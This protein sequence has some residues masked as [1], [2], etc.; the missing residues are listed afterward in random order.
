M[1]D[2]V[3][4]YERHFSSPVFA[5][6]WATWGFSLVAVLVG[7]RLTADP[8]V[9]G[10]GL[11]MGQVALV[12][13]LSLIVAAIILSVVATMA[14]E[15]GLNTGMLLRPAFGIA[16]SWLFSAIVAV[17]YLIWTALE[18]N[19]AATLAIAS[20]DVL[21]VTLAEGVPI[22]LGAV[23]IGALS[24]LGMRHFAFNLVRPALV[25]IGLLTFGLALISMSSQG[26]R[27]G[28]SRADPSSLMIAAQHIVLYTVIFLPLV[29]DTARF[30]KR[31]TYA[32]SSIGLGFGI[33][34]GGSI[35]VGAILG[36]AGTAPNAVSVAAT[37]LVSA[38]ALAAVVS[39]IW[40]FAGELVQPFG[41]LYGGANAA[42]AVVLRRPPKFFGW[43]LAAVSAGLALVFDESQL[44]P[45]AEV[46]SF[47][48]APAFVVLMVDFWLIRD[49]RYLVDEMYERKGNYGGVNLVGFSA[50]I[51]GLFVGYVLNPVGPDVFLRGVAEVLPIAGAWS[52]T[53]PTLFV[54]MAVTAVIY[55]TVGK[56]RLREAD[57][58][59]HVRL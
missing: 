44:F 49:H 34:V 1:L 10:L 57:V 13:P 7:V 27:I 8:A 23:A 58:V 28:G 59:S 12:A 36:A 19:V 16:G 53:V 41:F 47:L 45:T 3:A 21:D 46:F 52:E 50:Y 55:W 24:F 22:V 18:L 37:L 31:S 9:G 40:V 35:F 32:V 43:M 11:S 26:L 15:S 17:A 39:L 14:F 6:L 33:A 25:W 38:S 51:A 30:A 20:M 48:M 5:A 42:S 56:W 4:D 29:V 54:S 2:P